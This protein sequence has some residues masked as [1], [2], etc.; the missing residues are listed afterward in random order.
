M[1]WDK[2]RAHVAALRKTAN[3]LEALIPHEEDIVIEDLEVISDADVIE[4]GVSLQPAEPA[5]DFFTD[6]SDAI[7]KAL[8][9][10]VVRG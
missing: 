6:I 8:G 4:A 5:K 3:D 7:E 1:K 10:K 2:L 9:P